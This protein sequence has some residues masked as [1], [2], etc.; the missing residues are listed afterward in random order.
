MLNHVYDEPSA[1]SQPREAAQSFFCFFFGH[2]KE[3]SSSLG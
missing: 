2:K 1:F 3:D